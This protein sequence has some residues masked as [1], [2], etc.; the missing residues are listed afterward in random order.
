MAQLIACQPVF[1]LPAR[2]KARRVLA[3]QGWAFADDFKFPARTLGRLV[4]N[5]RRNEAWGELS[6]ATQRQREGF[7]RTVTKNGGKH[8]LRRIDKQESKNGIRRLKGPNAK[9]HF[10]QTLRGLFQWAKHAGYI[11]HVERP[12]TEG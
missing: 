6:I 2:S 7:L 9:R 1:G 4:E 3:R 8:P 5:Y 12:A 10:R 11:D